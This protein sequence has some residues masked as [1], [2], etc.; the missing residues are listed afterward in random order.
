[1]N[2]QFFKMILVIFFI[3]AAM[4]V[5]V[6]S[7]SGIY[8]LSGKCKQEIYCISYLINVRRGQ[9]LSSKSVRE[10]DLHRGPSSKFC[11]LVHLK[12]II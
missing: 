11:P 3:R 2:F 8:D 1:M 12:M 6:N 4:T 10:V 5:N 9:C 7:H